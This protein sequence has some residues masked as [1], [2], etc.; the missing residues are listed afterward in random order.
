M[1]KKYRIENTRKSVR[2]IGIN[3]QQTTGVTDVTI[4]WDDEEGIGL[5]LPP[6]GDIV[7]LPE[8][9]VKF[10][11]EERRAHARQVAKAIQEYVI[12]NNIR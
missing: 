9:G 1:K 7:G 3:G 4:V 8:K 5:E 6:Y 12:Q 11:T 2:A 10:D